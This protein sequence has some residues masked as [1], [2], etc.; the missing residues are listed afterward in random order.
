MAGNDKTVV[1][2]VSNHGLGHLGQIAPVVQELIARYS[3]VR[4]IVRCDHP[5]SVVR[6]FVGSRVVLD[7][8]P[9]EAALIMRGPTVIDVPASVAAYRDLHAAWDEHLEREAE[10]LMALTPA[11]LVADVPY[12]SL[13]AASRIGVPTIGFCSINWLDIFRHYCGH[14]RD[15]AGIL[16]TIE[17]AYHSADIF[18]QPR[19]HMMM[20]DLPNRRSIGP[21]ARI[22][23]RQRDEVVAAL[24]IAPNTRLVCVTFG[25]VRL[26][27]RIVLPAL[28]GVHWIVPPGCVSEGHNST[29]FTHLGISFIDLLTSVD[30]VLTKDGYCTFVEAAC[31]GV[32]LVSV[33]RADWPESIPL[34]EWA[35]QN[36]N[37]AIARGGIADA[38]GLEAAISAVAS[39]RRKMRV[40]ATGVAEAVDVIAQLA[41]LS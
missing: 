9:P 23:R 30:L 26:E 18:L 14:E 21:V 34:V 24:E 7:S 6:G 29:Q 22:G 27:N 19:P 20:P 13:A 11:V 10:R 37:F 33:P 32:G 38:Q 31:N 28:R 2:D 5:V 36:V 39:A 4:V 35:D 1:F 17:A 41:G 40:D 16:H 15:T 8:S 3:A 25:G 12:L